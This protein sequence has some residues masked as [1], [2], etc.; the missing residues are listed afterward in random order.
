MHLKLEGQLAHNVVAIG[1]H[2]VPGLDAVDHGAPLGSS[3]GD[4]PLIG[5]VD[6]AYYYLIFI[7]KFSKFRLCMR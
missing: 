3:E 5:L 2:N 6:T 4:G 7:P 1:A